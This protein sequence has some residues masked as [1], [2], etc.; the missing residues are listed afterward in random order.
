MYLGGNG[1]DDINKYK[2]PTAWD[3]STITPCNK[4]FN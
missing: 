3:V 1:G 4:L 2:L